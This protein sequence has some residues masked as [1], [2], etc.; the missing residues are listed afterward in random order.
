MR[1]QVL[2]LV[3]F[4][5]FGLVAPQAVV[6]AVEW[7]PFSPTTDDVVTIV[8]SGIWRDSCV[9]ELAEVH[10]DPDP[11]DFPELYPTVDLPLPIESRW[12]VVLQTSDGGCLSA[13]MPFSVSAP[14]GKL[15]E[16]H[17][18]VL[19]QIRDS[20]IVPTEVSTFDI[21]DFPVAPAEE[22]QLLLHGGRFRVTV[23]WR[24]YQGETGTGRAAPNPTSDSGI[25]TFFGA[26]NWEVLVKVL[27][28]CA[29][30]GHFWVFAAAA[31]DVEYT[32]RVEDLVGEQV[33]ERT[34][35]LGTRSPAFT[36]ARAFS[37]CGAP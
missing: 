25:F 27:D 32:L 9:P 7:Q 2:L 37:L 5:F 19:V 17:H 13:L 33:W 12:A 11:A 22:H 26:K 35:S 3:L 4:L 1:I 29:I 6:A 21:V 23:T 31:T 18:R 20:Q 15:S 8:A 28:G 30:N 36:D 16:G 24:N 34:N 14:L 10:R